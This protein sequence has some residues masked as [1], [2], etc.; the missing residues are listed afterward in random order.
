MSRKD[1]ILIADALRSVRPA[2]YRAGIKASESPE[3]IQ[4]HDT[5]YAVAESLSY[6]NAAFDSDRFWDACRK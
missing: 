3:A 4:W 2:S 6:G 1:Y 5:V